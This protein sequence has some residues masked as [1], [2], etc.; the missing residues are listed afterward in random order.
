MVRDPEATLKPDE[1]RAGDIV[2]VTAND[3]GEVKF[4]YKL[5]PEDNTPS[6][7]DI[8]NYLYGY[9][10]YKEYIFGHVVEKN[11]SGIVVECNGSKIYCYLN[12]Y[13]SYGKYIM[14]EKKAVSA[15]SADIIASSDGRSGSKVFVR[16]RNGDVK[17]VFIYE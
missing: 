7:I 6:V 4:I 11:G 12:S 17:E 9:G 15:T 5:F 8:D 2:S 1:I 3:K 10:S 13:A 14:D 16:V